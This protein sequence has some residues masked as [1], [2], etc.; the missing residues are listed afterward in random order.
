MPHWQAAVLSGSACEG[1]APV[2]V[3]AAATFV[4]NG[5]EVGIEIIV[6]GLTISVVGTSASAPLVA[7]IFTRLDLTTAASN[8]L[9][10]VYENR[11]AFNDVGSAEYPLPSGASNTNTSSNSSCG[12]LCTAGTGWDGPSGVGS[13]NGAKLSALPVS[14]TGLQS[15]P[16]S[17]ICG[18]YGRVGARGALEPCDEGGCGCT[19]GGRRRASEISWVGAL[20]VLVFVGARHRNRS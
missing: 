14:S 9:S 1:R 2:D 16:D 18:P 5:A 7:G 10:W 19:V 6:N 3:S 11:S 15:Y 8:D 13:P 17:G 12:V 20:L 4:S